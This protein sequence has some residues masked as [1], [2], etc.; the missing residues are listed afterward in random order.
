MH[1]VDYEDDGSENR[2]RDE[3]Q[4]TFRN[5]IRVGEEKTLSF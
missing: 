5:E 1:T 3:S 2:D 4:D